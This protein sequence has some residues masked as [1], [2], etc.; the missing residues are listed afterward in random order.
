MKFLMSRFGGHSV[1]IGKGKSS[2]LNLPEDQSLD[3][4]L[5]QEVRSSRSDPP[6]LEPGRPSVV[7]LAFAN[8]ATFVDGGCALWR[9]DVPVLDP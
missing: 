4:M 7:V 1:T 3:H 8:A 6:K 9:A 5:D 2:D